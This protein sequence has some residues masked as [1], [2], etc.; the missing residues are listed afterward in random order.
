M[1]YLRVNNTNSYPKK[2]RRIKKMAA[3][4]GEPESIIMYIRSLH[5][6]RVIDWKIVSILTPI[7]SNVV[8]PK[9]I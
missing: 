7:L 1:H 5:P 6:S 3:I 4:A 8:M 9:F 2:I